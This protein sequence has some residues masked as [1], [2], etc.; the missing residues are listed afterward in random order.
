[1]TPILLQVL[2]S[3]EILFTKKCFFWFTSIG[4]LSLHDHFKLQIVYFKLPVT[5]YSNYA[6]HEIISLLNTRC[7]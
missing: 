1:M 7:I 3:V 6:G 4:T 2:P 5:A